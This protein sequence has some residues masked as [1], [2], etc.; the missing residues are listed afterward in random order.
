M[1]QIDLLKIRAHA[2]INLTLDITG[3]RSDGYHTLSTIMQ[4]VSLHD[5]VTVALGRGT[6]GDI[7]IACDKPRIPCDHRNL[8]YRAADAFFHASGILNPGTFID[9]EKRI[10]SQA[11]LGGGSS[12]AAAVLY[13]LNLMFDGPFTGETL[14]QIGAAIGAD[15]P[16]C[17]TGG[18]QLAEG[19][20]DT[21][22]SLPAMPPIPIV[23]VKPPF[24]SSTAEAYY[25]ADSVSL[26]HPSAQTAAEALRNGSLSALAASLGNSFESVVAPEEIAALKRR[27]CESG[28]IGSGMSGSGTAVFGLFAS[29][30]AAEMCRGAMAEQYRDAFLAFPSHHGVEAESLPQIL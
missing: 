18:T 2:K 11:G 23:I 5:H 6:A 21:L 8:A 10:P 3:R 27:F 25:A 9:I 4:S 28:A 17:L 13:A 20:G 26:C 15:V 12:D 29:P 19:I 1:N 24:S 22:F 7:R 16:F 30:A 14:L